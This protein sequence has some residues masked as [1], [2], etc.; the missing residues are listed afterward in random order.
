MRRLLADRNFRLLVVGKTLSTFGDFALLIVLGIWVKELTG[1]NGAAGS[2]FLVLGIPAIASPLFGPLIDRF[3][4]RRVLIVN[5]LLVGAAVLFLLMVHDRGDIWIIY[6]V[7]AVYGISMQI[8]EAARAGLLVTML[9]EDLLGDANGLLSASGQGVRLAAP[10]LG[11]GMFAAFGGGSVAVFDA[12]M[13]VL[14]AA[15]LAAVHADDI[16]RPVERPRY[17]PDVTVGIRHIWRTR[18]VRRLIAVSVAV[19]AVIGTSEVAIFAFVDQ[20]LH[21]SPT[22]LGII[23]TVQGVGSIGAGVLAGR[24]IRRLDELRTAAAA[25]AV[26]A[27]GFLCF[28]APSLATAF[29]GAVLIGVAVALFDVSYATLLQ[30]RTDAEMQGRVFTAAGALIGP[31]YTLS[32]A[33]GAVLIGVTGFRP[34]YL[35]TSLAL[36]LGAIALLG[37]PTDERVAVAP[38]PVNY[39]A[40]D[41]RSVE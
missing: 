15:F 9:N 33:L 6:A 10:L 32:I 28:V 2:V 25:L 38:I 16:A 11:A 23:A 31:P 3:P 27:I 41:S 14:G 12:A 20:G 40:E 30:R 5:D 8:V 1:S 34:I 7:A 22:F 13:F 26:G 35:A 21:R 24:V 4:R 17:L 39:A 19:V 29:T 37:R 36:A 18:E